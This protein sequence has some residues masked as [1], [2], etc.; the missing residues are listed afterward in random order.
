MDGDLKVGD[1]IRR[2]VLRSKNMDKFEAYNNS[3][4][5]DY[6]AED[7]IFNVCIYKI[8]TPQFNEVNRSQYGN[9]CDFKN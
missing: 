8:D 9:G 4:D 1:R 3:I 7:A 2:T 6:D 5:Q